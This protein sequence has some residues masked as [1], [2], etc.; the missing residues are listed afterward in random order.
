M[1]SCFDTLPDLI[2]AVRSLKALTTPELTPLPSSVVN[3]N[4]IEFCC[5]TRGGSS[6]QPISI[7]YLSTVM[8]SCANTGVIPVKSKVMQTMTTSIF[9]DVHTKVQVIYFLKVVETSNR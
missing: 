3:S 6:F 9:T 7:L 2:V 4:V 1:S 5:P 8:D